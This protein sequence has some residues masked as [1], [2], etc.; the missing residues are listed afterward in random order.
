M[1]G[2]FIILRLFISL[3]LVNIFY[4]YKSKFKRTPILKHLIEY[5]DNK[6]C[7][8]FFIYVS[9]NLIF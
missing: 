7:W 8:L 2:L 4:K 6:C 9:L 5:F 1:A 3:F